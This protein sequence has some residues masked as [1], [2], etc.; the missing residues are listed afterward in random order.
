MTNG[1]STA[2]ASTRCGEH[3]ESERGEMSAVVLGMHRS[4]TSVA[5]RMA[6]MLEL[7]MCH[8]DDLSRDRQGNERGLWESASLV[9][10]NDRLLAGA[11]A[12]WWCPPTPGHDWSQQLT[13]HSEE[14]RSVFE[15]AYPVPEWIWK[16]PRTCLTLPF[17]LQALTVRPPVILMTRD[18][19]EIA[20]SL[21]SRN[22]FSI[23]AGLALWERYLRAAVQHM[24]GLPVLVSRYAD[25]LT[26]PEAWIVNVASFLADTGH[27]VRPAKSLLAIGYVGSRALHRAASAELAS[28]DISPNQLRL[29]ATLNKLAG[30]HACFQAGDLGPET[31]GTEKFFADQ[32]HRRGLAVVPAQ[33]GRPRST[34][35]LFAEPRVKRQHQHPPATVVI[36]SRDEGAWL[37]AT[38]DRLRATAPPETE[39]IVVDDHSRDAS[40]LPLAG[41]DDVTLIRATHRLGIAGARNLG[42][43][44]ARGQLLVFSDAHVD[45]SPGW[46]AALTSAL[47]EPDVAAAGPALT[48]YRDRSHRVH[49]LTFAG[50]E[51]NV[52]WLADEQ[53][54]TPFDVPLLPGCFLAVRREVFEAVGGFDAGMTG[55]GAEDLELCLRLW[56]TGYRCVSVPQAVVAHRFRRLGSPPIDRTGFLHNLLRMATLHLAPERLR[57]L[58]V[59][60]REQPEL[61]G[62]LARVLAGDVARRR[63][64]TEALC[65]FEDRWFFERFGPDCYG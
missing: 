64:E 11:S 28:D 37:T 6:S 31:T 42:A 53:R 5:T 41:R 40:T 59:V 15:A 2:S 20:A 65:W 34:I 23:R 46:L 36:I 52:S 49:G 48:H 14:A 45:P 13:T 27:R 39:I 29:A 43:E 47:A 61:P 35:S 9:R 26:D 4:G 8:A 19:L 24:D 22:Q 63:A 3:D 62:A 51:L 44:R 38:T 60:L 30:A 33:P 56:R 7:E 10:Y 21:Q 18:P 55:Y 54:D 58:L 17:W 16:D 25:L 32:R 57:A 12:A 50:P 1:S